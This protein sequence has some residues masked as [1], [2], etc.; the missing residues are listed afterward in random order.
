MAPLSAARIAVCDAIASTSTIP[1]CS[2]QYGVGR[3]ASTRHEA[4]A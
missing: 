2:S 3:E 1:N 4:W